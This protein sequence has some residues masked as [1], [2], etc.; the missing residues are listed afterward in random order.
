METK[1]VDGLFVSRREQAPDFVK[2]NLSF[3][4][5]KFYQY[6]LGTQNEKGYVN[7]DILESK[8]GKL[9]AKLNDFKP[10]EESTQAITF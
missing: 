3:Q 7:V 9:Y 8:E 10:K 4:A 2:A 5:D 6:M 1:F